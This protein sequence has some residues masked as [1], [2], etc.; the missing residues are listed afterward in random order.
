MAELMPMP[1]ARRAALERLF[2]EAPAR[3]DWFGPVFLT[4]VSVERVAGIV[5]ELERRYGPCREAVE[6]N[7]GFTVRLAEADIPARLALDVQ[8]RIA[9]LRFQPAVPTVGGL[10][11]HVRAV[12]ALPGR[13][14]ALV[15]SDGRVRAEHAADLPLAVGSAFKLV[16]LRAVAAA[17]EEGRLA[18]DQVVRLDPSWRSSGSGILQDWPDGSQLTVAT[19]ANLMI[20]I[21]DN[22]ATDALIHLVGREV[23]EALSPRNTPFLT[24][25]EAFILKR[26]VDG[27]LRQEWL[28]ADAVRRRA[29]LATVA[30]LSLPPPSGLALVTSEIEWFLTAQEI[31]AQLEATHQLP[32]FTIKPG[33]VGDGH[34]RSIAFK[35]GTEPGVHNLSALAVTA[36]GQRHCV[37]MTWNDAENLDTELLRGPF[38]AVLRLLSDEG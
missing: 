36:A 31:R 30:E 9:G 18:W 35:G 22:T 38:R 12:A 34:W 24:T 29:L 32:P 21:S 3:A 20:S 15:V 10:D 4:Q 13:T 1:D 33:P 11:D 6:T 8:G 25:R 37:V 7:D 19:L 5:A 28:A 23:I 14:A 27:E 2:R 16:V 17:C 26:G